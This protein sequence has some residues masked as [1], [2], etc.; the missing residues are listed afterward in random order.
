MH[1]SAKMST[2]T[3]RFNPGSAQVLINLPAKGPTWFFISQNDAVEDFIGGCQTEDNSIESLQVLQGSKALQSDAN[4][5]QA[6]MKTLTP[7]ADPLH[8]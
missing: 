4:L 2:L 7:K 6:I 5:Y 1:S 8:F 3:V